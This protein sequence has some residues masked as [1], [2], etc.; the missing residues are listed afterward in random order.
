M[1]WLRLHADCG[2]YIKTFV[3]IFGTFSFPNLLRQKFFR[4]WATK[5]EVGAWPKKR[6]ERRASFYSKIPRYFGFERTH[7]EAFEMI[8]LFLFQIF[9]VTFLKE[10]EKAH[11]KIKS[12]FFIEEICDSILLDHFL[13]FG[14][15]EW[16]D[17]K[18]QK[19]NKAIR[20]RSHEP[21]K[22]T[23]P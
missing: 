10:G 11:K 14:N 1:F 19:W 23:L 15:T 16:E 5:W 4:F 22:R 9:K 17:K 12:C 3:L 13:P 18:M 7:V 8:Y 21:K 20:K 2:D 6:K